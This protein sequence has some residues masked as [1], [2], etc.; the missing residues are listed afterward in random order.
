MIA[1]GDIQ[2]SGDFVSLSGLMANTGTGTKG[3]CH[4]DRVAMCERSLMPMLSAFVRIRYRH[5]DRGV[6]S[7]RVRGSPVEHLVISPARPPASSR[8]PT[9]S[10]YSLAPTRRQCPF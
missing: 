3:I 2:R 8:F 10:S 7:Q 1:H 4:W 6:Y 5:L 9:P